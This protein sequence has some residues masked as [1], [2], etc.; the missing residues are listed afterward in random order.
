MRGWWLVAC[1]AVGGCG[2]GAA[3]DPDA[4]A[5]S[6]PTFPPPR[7]PFLEVAAG[8]EHSCAREGLPPAADVA[9]GTRHG[10][11]LATDG[12]VWCWGWQGALGVGAQLQITAAR[13][14]AE[15]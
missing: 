10:C 14:I 2:A 11:A 4:A 7:A 3:A 13:P 9:L 6:G 8:Y 15:P 12:Q 5:D 1:L